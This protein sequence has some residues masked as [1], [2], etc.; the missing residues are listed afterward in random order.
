MSVETGR[1]SRVE[2]FNVLAKQRT[3]RFQLPFAPISLRCLR[4]SLRRK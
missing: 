1:T 4:G 2:V 3:A